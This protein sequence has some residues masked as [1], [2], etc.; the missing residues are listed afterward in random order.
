M[1][2]RKSSSPSRELRPPRFRP[3]PLGSVR[4]EG[5]LAAQLRLQAD[6]LSGHL[7]EIW[8]DV[9]DSRWF[10]GTAEGWERAPYWLDGFIPLAFVLGDP[11]LR[12]KA[13]ARVGEILDRQQD[14]GW[15]GPREMV[16][17]NG[18]A[19]TPRYD[20]WGQILATK[21][22]WQYGEATG[23]PR[24]FSA[25]LKAFRGLDREIDRKPLHDWGQFRWFEALVALYGLYER[26]PQPWLWDLGVKLHAQGFHWRDLF[27][28]W[29]MTEATPHGRWNFMSH[30]VNNAMAVK[31]P[32]LWWRLSGEPA[33]RAAASKMIAALDRHHGTAVGIFTG[34]ECLAGLS[35]V[36]GTELCSVVELAYSLE[37]LLSVLG[38]PAFGDR[39]ERIV[40]NAL[41][42]TFSPDMWAHQYDQQVNQV[43]CTI[44]ERRRWTTNRPD[45]NIFG[46]E[47]DFG[48]CTANLSQ[49]WPK[50]V[51]SLWMQ[52]DA[53]PA[54]MAWGPSRAELTVRGV[55]VVVRVETDYPFRDT[56]TVFIETKR[57]SRFALRMR[58]PEWARGAA[59]AV[60]TGRAQPAK[61]GTLHTIDREWE[62]TTRISV[63]LPME[64]VLVKRPRGAVSVER[65]QLVYAL[66]VGEDWRRVN[67][68]KPNR[69]P[70][71]ADWEVRP[72]TP[73][74]YALDVSKGS[75]AANIR[76]EE[77]PVGPRPFSPEG[78]PVKAV[79]RGRRVPGWR[80]VDAAADE[81][82]EGPVAS[83]EPV[84]D[85]VL[86]PYGCTNLRV[87]EFPVTRK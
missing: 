80:E 51:A 44:D 12:R 30:V 38:E 71:H 24:V 82:P 18:A 16:V 73:W 78:A 32:A 40:Y 11:A 47:P 6:G 17:Q 70:P 28:R 86:I 22:L 52:D 14:D 25:L 49:G 21:M 68:D 62:G 50:F 35:P 83:A 65:G 34:D 43:S 37:V 7:D 23:D 66:K 81:V 39:L 76:F 55:P 72:T 53:G 13:D 9:R 8:P 1:T 67:A 45:A 85:L 84:E 60:G 4:P 58:I 3:L 59:V 2:P 87:T 29:P 19:A 57:A 77:C 61:P 5:W 79:T 54:L 64:A 31:S 33:D 36:Q 26:D 10:G 75:L 42:A 15:L 41:P 56:A 69:E 46:L 20:L 27:A 74:N 48:C 63:K